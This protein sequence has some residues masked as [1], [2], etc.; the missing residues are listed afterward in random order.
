MKRKT[1]WFRKCPKCKTLIF[2]CNKY[3]LKRAINNKYWCQ[4]C[5]AI[6]VQN[7]PEIKFIRKKE[8]L[9]KT[10]EDIVGMKKAKEW[11]NKLKIANYGKTY[12]EKYGDNSKNIRWKV[13]SGTRGKTYEQIYGKEKAIELKKNKQRPYEDLY[14]IERTK[15]IKEKQNINRGSKNPEVRKKMRLSSIRRIKNIVGQ[16]HPNYNPKS[17]QILEQ[18][19]KDLGIID[20]KHAENG[21][22]YYIKDLGYWVDG[23]SSSKN[24]VI[25][26][27]ENAH[28]KRNER[29]IR[30]KQEIID[31]LKCKFI[32]IKEW[33]HEDYELSVHT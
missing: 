26:Y 8:R 33:E 4:K 30:R 31:Y 1:K 20:L 11:K 27:Y 15:I 5:K 21:G 14:G 18:K 13:G 32:E 19:A 10:F 9:G 2:Y 25:E 16:I 6:E 28:K 22:E 23:Y 7:R 29:D 17:I 12:D 3:T 24:I